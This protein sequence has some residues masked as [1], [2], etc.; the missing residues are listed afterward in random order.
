M[1]LTILGSGTCVPSTER[2]S[3]ANFLK[4]RESNILVDC[5]PGTLRQMEG[6]GLDYKNLDY[7]FITHFHSDHI[8]DLVPL[9]Q[10]LNWTPGFDRKEKL[11]LVGPVGFS[12]F[13]NSLLQLFPG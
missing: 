1:K 9:L 4:I 11:T 12:K 5:G 10:A 13:Y 8:A 2:G 7:V 3:P 6:A